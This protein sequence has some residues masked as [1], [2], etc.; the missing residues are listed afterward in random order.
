MLPTCCVGVMLQE[1]MTKGS[2]GK[3]NYSTDRNTKKTKMNLT[4]GCARSRALATTTKVWSELKRNSCSCERAERCRRRRGGRCQGR[5]SAA[6]G[7]CRGN[8]GAAVIGGIPVWSWGYRRRS[9]RNR[10]RRRRGSASRR[11]STGGATGQRS[12]S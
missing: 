10:Q 2:C 6:R 11:W 5:R 4:E 9:R 12:P 8:T 1:S 3:R 7:R